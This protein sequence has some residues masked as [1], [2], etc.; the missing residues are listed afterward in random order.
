VTNW[1]EK[2]LVAVVSRLAFLVCSDPRVIGRREAEDIRKTLD[3][4]KAA[5]IARGPAPG[6]DLHGFLEKERG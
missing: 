2:T 3:G 6:F 4:I 5:I 1:E